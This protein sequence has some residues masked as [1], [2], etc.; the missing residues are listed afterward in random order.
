MKILIISYAFF[1]NQTPRANRTTQLALEF[2]RLGHD[3]TVIMPE[4]DTEYYKEYSNKSGVE[5]KSLG[6]LK[7]NKIKGKSFLIRALSR[8]LLLLFEYPNI[9]L[10]WMIKRA[11]K[12]ESGYDLLVSVAVPHPIHWGVAWALKNNKKLSKVWAADCGDPYMGCKTDTINKLFHFKYV[13]KYWCKKCNYIVVP[14]ATAMSGYYSE[15]HSKIKVIPQGFNLNEVKIP[16]YIPNKIPTFAYAG[17]LAL[18]FRNPYPLLDYLCT[19][20]L[21]FKFIIF[22][23]SEI[24]KPYLERLKGKLELRKYIP[25]TELLTFLSSMD[26]LVN[27]ENNTVVQVPSKL[28]DYSIVNRPVISIGKELNTVIVDEF[29]IGNYMQKIEMPD[30]SKYDIKN[31][32]QKFIN[33]M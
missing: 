8:L 19:L 13:E 21:D 22:N 20:D 5:F 4:L 28:I 16:K 6:K 29:L 33:L 12:K 1:P 32:A 17:V 25:R 23:E 24:I 26:F 15:F 30:I 31:V 7:Y 2:V 11:L 10:T 9:Q 3:V 14:E 27:F 18:H